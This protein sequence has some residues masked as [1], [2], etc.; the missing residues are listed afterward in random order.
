[1]GVL[2]RG[3]WQDRW[4]DTERSG[5][6]FERD[7]ARFRNWI[8][9]DGSAGPSGVGGFAAAPG[10]YHLYVSY[11][12]PWAQRTLILRAL[13]GLQQQISVD[14]VHPLM[15]QQGW[16][17]ATDFA[18]ATGDRLHGSAYLHQLYTRAQADISGRV[19]VPLLWDKQ[20]D[21]IV[22]NESSEIIRML[23]SAFDGCGAAVG[24][25]YPQPL[26][27]QIDA[28]NAQIYPALNNGVYRAGFATS[29][30]AYDEAVEQ[31]FAMLDRLDEHLARRRYLVGNRLTEADI[32][33]FTTLVR[34]DPVYVSH[35]KCDRRRIADYAHL[36][37]YLR[38]L[39]QHPGF[40]ETTQMEHIRHHYFRSHP[41]INPHGI[42]PVGPQ[43][44]L[45]AAHNREQLNHE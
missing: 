19:T 7:Q 13:K 36:A 33:L 27:A 20:R 6:R 15:L 31:V 26:R 23:N 28:W 2:V 42:V 41:T 5:G 40:A 38:D 24:D 25:Y 22:S 34:F 9:A 35:F 39:Y 43:I 18:G 16:S 1:M 30:G 10:R 44:D 4:Y 8:T 12:C 3:R 11:A 29:Q 37:G 14:V 32:R 45:L 21:T 17:F